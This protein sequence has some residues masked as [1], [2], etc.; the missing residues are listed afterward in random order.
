MLFCCQSCLAQKC[1][2]KVAGLGAAAMAD[3][4]VEPLTPDTPIPGRARG[5]LLAGLPGDDS[6]AEV[7]RAFRGCAVAR[8]HSLG[9]DAGCGF[10]GGTRGRAIFG[11]PVPRAGVRA[12]PLP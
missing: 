4:T 6:V 5:Y 8:L 3:S 7:R 1:Y 12:F 11:G 9:A 2:L 10:S